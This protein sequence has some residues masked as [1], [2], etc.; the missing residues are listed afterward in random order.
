MTNECLRAAFGYM[1]PS[2]FLDFLGVAVEAAEP[3]AEAAAAGTDGFLLAAVLAFFGGL[4]MN[5]TPCVLPM[6]P[7]NLAIIGRRFSRGLVYAL[8]QALAC[9]VLGLFAACGGR[10]FGE[11]HSSRV[12]N[13]VVVAVMVFLALCLFDVLHFDLSRWRRFAGTRG[14]TAAGAIGV[15]TAGVFSALLAGACV[16]PALA[17]LLVATADG[18]AAGKPVYG[19]LPFLFGLGMG[20]P[21]PFVAAGLGRLPRPGVWMVWFKRALGVCVLAFAVFYGLRV[22]RPAERA[23]EPTPAPVVSVPAARPILYKISAPWCTVCKKMEATTLRDPEVVAALERFEVR[24]VVV[25]RMSEL[26]RYSDLKALK[27]P[28]V[29][30]YIIK[31]CDHE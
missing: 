1:E 7:V 8:G 29:P 25:E 16:A 26:R 19:V 30:A 20:F 23:D 3:A 2:R 13:C 22:F 17:A 6:V 12:F 24:E 31:E 21:W 14:G 15:F 28:G 9:G 27:I 18:V 10:M 11:I 5:L 4:A